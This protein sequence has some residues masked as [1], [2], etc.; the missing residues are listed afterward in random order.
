MT[1]NV[2]NEIETICECRHAF[3]LFIDGEGAWSKDKF[4][5]NCNMHE[6]DEDSET[7]GEIAASAG[8]SVTDKE[9]DIAVR[10]IDN[11]S[12]DESAYTGESFCSDES[13]DESEVVNES[14]INDSSSPPRTDH[15][16]RGGNVKSAEVPLNSPSLRSAEVPLNSP[17]LRSDEF[18]TVS[19]EPLRVITTDRCVKPRRSRRWNMSFTDEQMRRIERENELLLRKIMAQ[20]KP[21]HQVLGERVVQSRISSSAIN[22]KRLQKK[23]DDDNMLLVKRIQQAKSCVLTNAS[24]MSSRLNFL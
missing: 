12:E 2:D 17:G 21:R 5:S 11:A 19:D 23:I 9:K 1:A 24:K 20:Q 22:R 4:V 7:E 8:P 13:C 16:Q 18:S 6:I 10:D 15:L 14:S 3:A